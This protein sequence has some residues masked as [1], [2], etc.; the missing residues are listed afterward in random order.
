MSRTIFRTSLLVG[1]LVLVFTTAV[2]F[3]LRYSQVQDETYD[4][5]RQEALYAEQGL[6]RSGEEYLRSLGSINRITWIRPDGDVI[7]DN[8]FPLE[9]NQLGCPE[10]RAALEAGEGQGIRRSGSSGQQ[11]MYVAH[12]CADGTILRLSRPLSA[13]RTAILSVTPALWVVVLALLLSLFPA[14]V[15]AAP[16]AYDVWVNGVRLT[17]TAKSIGVTGEEDDVIIEIVYK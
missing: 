3:V 17:L 16:S 11:T 9:K 14:T 1:L 4:A 7:F 2:F 5:L 12:L 8:E 15:F 13:V 6:L 10:V